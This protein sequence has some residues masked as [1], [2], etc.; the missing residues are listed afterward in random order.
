MIMYLLVEDFAGHFVELDINMIGI[1]QEGLVIDRV[2]ADMV[3]VHMIFVVVTDMVD[4]IS[5]DKAVV[6]FDVDIKD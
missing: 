5:A 4:K 2:F 6:G 1:D 3:A